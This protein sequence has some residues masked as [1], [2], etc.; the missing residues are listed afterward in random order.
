MKKLITLALLYSISTIAGAA[1]AT[2]TDAHNITAT[3]VGSVG[4]T[5]FSVT[6]A[7]N[8]RFYTM[9]PTIDPFLYLANDDGDLTQD[10]I[11]THDDDGCYGL[12]TL[13]GPAGSFSNSLIDIAL[14]S[15]DYILGISDYTFS[16][17]E[18][19]SG[20]NTNDLTGVANI[21]I[22]TVG[23]SDPG[24]FSAGANITATPLP[25]AVWLMGSGLLGVLG[26]GRKNKVQAVAA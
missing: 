26:L 23:I 14:G 1:T 20:I 24:T 5:S 11:I 15:G 16:S 17:S 13:C 3:G 22:S 4:Y 6:S 7:G 12:D 19:I 18:F 21:V 9:G 2:F 10:D 25:A 8:F